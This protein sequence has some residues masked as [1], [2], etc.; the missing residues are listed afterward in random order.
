MAGFN[1]ENSR[2]LG[3]IGLVGGVLAVLFI[4]VFCRLVQFHFI[5][6][7]PLNREWKYE[8]SALRG[9]ICDRNGATLAESIPGRLVFIDPRDERLAKLKPELRTRLTFDLS[10]LLEVDE[11]SIIEAF[12]KKDKRFIPMATTAKESVISNL[13]ARLD[14]KT[15]AGVGMT[16][17]TIRAYPN[18]R[19]LSHVLG[20]VNSEGVG[21]AGL[22]LKYDKNLRGIPGMIEGSRDA[23][24]KEIRTLRRVGIPPVPGADIY[25]T[26]DN[27]IQRIVESA[28]SAAVIGADARSG[29]AIVQRVRTGEILAMAAY[30]DF[31]PGAYQEGG[32]NNWSNAAISR[33]YEPGSV[34]KSFIVAAALNERLITPDTIFDVHQGFWIYAG[35]KLTDHVIGH[36]DTRTALAKS[37]NI[38]CAKIGLE[39][40]KPTVRDGVAFKKNELFE[41]YI[42]AFGFG[43]PLEIGLNG[44]ERGI[45]SA[46]AKWDVLS[47]SRIA[48]GQGIAV[49][50]LQMLNG[51]CTLANGGNLMRPYIVDRIVDAQGETIQTTPR[52]IGRPIRK[53]V[54]ASVSGML[55]GVTEEGGTAPKAATQSYTVA[56]KTGTAQIP[57]AGGY[58]NTD[59][60]ATFVGFFPA[61]APEIGV[62]VTV[63]RPD[64]KKSRTGG[65]ISAPVFAQVAEEI[66]RYL[67][68]PSDKTTGMND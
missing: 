42:R 52:L 36:I 53:E 39:L 5:E 6:S 31:N 58:S 10:E 37:S 2:L 11:D 33:N 24:R 25:L 23:H 8:L 27:N 50:A 1:R 41:R 56:G 22:E 16:D 4:A 34:M 46:A 64:P 14:A 32:S 21:S 26:I 61:T 65:S 19:R 38:A 28:L 63:E 51:Y 15:I 9:R 60:N 66:G 20:F 47:P 18:G 12:S 44:E 40:A 57:I 17:K 13:T 29:I 67:A 59:H 49:T 7:A 62:I 55:R 43:S 54:A 68:I 48:I 35:K 3:V 30:P 45:L